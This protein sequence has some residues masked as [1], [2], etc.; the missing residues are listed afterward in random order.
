MKLLQKFVLGKSGEH[1]TDLRQAAKTRPNDG[2]DTDPEVENETRIL[3]A[4]LE[5]LFGKRLS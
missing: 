3:L 2:V 4:A 1:D 5:V